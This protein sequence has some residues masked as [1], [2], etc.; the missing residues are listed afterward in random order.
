MRVLLGHEAADLN[1]AASF[2]ASAPKGFR[3][4]VAAFA[5]AENK[6]AVAAAVDGGMCG[7]GLGRE[8]K[9]TALSCA[10]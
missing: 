8:S 1:L 10:W 4:D 7:F 6:L 3:E 9:L 2:L 5:G